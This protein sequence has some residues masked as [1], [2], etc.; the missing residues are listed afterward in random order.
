MK[1]DSS[2]EFDPLIRPWNFP[3]TL[4]GTDA[5]LKMGSSDSFLCVTNLPTN[6]TVKQFQELCEKFGPVVRCFLIYH[7]A[8]DESLGFGLV[9]YCSRAVACQAKNLLHKKQ[10]AQGE[11]H[12]DW[13]EHN[14]VN[15][16]DLYPRC[17]YVGNLPT[18]FC[19]IY[20]FRQLFTTVASPTYCQ[21]SIVNGVP[22]GFGVVEFR[23][24][25]DARKTKELLHGH[26]LNGNR[27]N[28]LFTSPGVSAYKL[29]NRIIEEQAKKLEKN[30][31]IIQ[32]PQL[33]PALLA[34]FSVVQNSKVAKTFQK[35]IN[36]KG[37]GKNASQVS[38]TAASNHAL[39]ALQNFFNQ[40]ICTQQALPHAVLMQGQ[41]ALGLPAPPS[42]AGQ[43]EGQQPGSAASSSS[44]G[45]GE[46][47][48]KQAAED[49]GSP[50]ERHKRKGE[51]V[52]QPQCPLNY[53]TMDN[54]IVLDKWSKWNLF[55]VWGSPKPVLD[56]VQSNCDAVE[57][58]NEA[59]NM[60][61][62]SRDQQS[63]PGASCSWQSAWAAGGQQSQE[64]SGQPIMQQGSSYDK[65][66][67]DMSPSDRKRKVHQLMPSP[68]PSPEH[69]YI[70]QHSQALGGH[71]ADSY[72]RYK[73]MKQ[74]AKARKPQRQFQ[75]W[76]RSSP[77]SSTAWDE[78]LTPSSSSESIRQRK[79]Q[80]APPGHSLG[81]ARA[82]TAKSSKRRPESE[83]VAARRSTETAEVVS[84]DETSLSPFIVTD[85]LLHWAKH[86]VSRKS[87][88]TIHN[89]AA[90][91]AT[92][93]ERRPEGSA[94]VNVAGNAS[95]MTSD[96]GRLV[97]DGG[98]KKA[99]R[100][101]CA[102]PGRHLAARERKT[103]GDSLADR[104]AAAL[105]NFVDLE[106]QRIT[107]TDLAYPKSSL[108]G[109]LSFGIGSIA[110]R[111]FRSGLPRA[112][113]TPVREIQQRAPL[114]SLR[115]RSTPKRTVRSKS[116]GVV[117]GEE[118]GARRR[119]LRNC[120]DTIE[121]S[122]HDLQPLCR[123]ARSSDHHDRG[124]AV[125]RATGMMPRE[126]SVAL[127]RTLIAAPHKPKRMPLELSGGHRPLSPEGQGDTQRQENRGT[128]GAPDPRVGRFDATVMTA[129][130]ESTHRSRKESKTARRKRH[131]SKEDD[132]RDRNKSSSG[133]GHSGSKSRGERRRKKK[134]RSHKRDGDKSSSDQEKTFETQTNVAGS[135]YEL[136]G[137]PSRSFDFVIST[138][139]VT[140]GALPRPELTRSR[141]AQLESGA[142]PIGGDVESPQAM[143]PAVKSSIRKPFAPSRK[144]ENREVNL[145]SASSQ[146]SRKKPKRSSKRSSKKK[147]AFRSRKEAEQD[148]AN[149]LPAGGA[150][151]PSSMPG[152]GE[153]SPQQRSE[154][155]P[156]HRSRSKS[157]R[158]SRENKETGVGS[159]GG[160]SPNDK[161]RRRKSKRKSREAKADKDIGEESPK[162]RKTRKSREEKANKNGE[163]ESPNDMQDRSKRKR[164]ET[165]QTKDQKGAGEQS[166][167]DRDE[168]KSKRKSRHSKGKKSARHSGRSSSQGDGGRRKHRRREKHDR[169]R[170][171]GR[172]R[173]K[174]TP[175]GAPEN[176]P[177]TY[178]FQWDTADIPGLEGVHRDLSFSTRHIEGDSPIASPGSPTGEETHTLPFSTLSTSSLRGKKRAQGS[179]RTS[180]KSDRR[181]PSR[182]SE[183]SSKRDRHRH[184]SRRSHRRRH[185]HR[186][187]DQLEAASP[188]SPASERA[189]P[190]ESRSPSRPTSPAGPRSPS[191]QA[192]PASPSGMISPSGLKSPS[193]VS[194]QESSVSPEPS[195]RKSQHRRHGKKHRHGPGRS[196]RHKRRHRSSRRS[197]S[198]R[199]RPRSR[200]RS[201]QRG[202][203]RH[204]STRKH[205]RH[206]KSA[207]AQSSRSKDGS[208]SPKR[209]PETSGSERTTETSTKSPDASREGKIG[210][211]RSRTISKSRSRRI[212]ESRSRSSRGSRS[213]SRE[214]KS[215]SRSSES[216]VEKRT[217]KRHGRSGGSR[218]SRSKR[219]RESESISRSAQGTSSV[220]RHRGKKRHHRHRKGHGKSRHRKPRSETVS[221]TGRSG[222]MRED[223]VAESYAAQST[224][225]Y[226]CLLMSSLAA[227]L[228]M[229]TCVLM[230]YYIITCKKQLANPG[231][232][233]LSSTAQPK[234]WH[235]P[236]PPEIFPATATPKTLQVYYCTTDHCKREARY[237]SRLLNRQ[238]RPC[239][240][241]YKHVCDIWMSEHPAHA[242]STGSVVSRDTQLQ[243]SIARQLAAVVGRSSQ[244]DIKVAANLFNACTDRGRRATTS[245]DA[246]RALF[247]RWKIGRWPRTTAVENVMAVWTFAGELSRDLNL[248]T[249][250][251]A[252]VG[253]DPENVDITAIELSQPR[254]LYARLGK[255]N[256]EAEQLLRAAVREAV[257]ELGD[258][259][260]AV[261]ALG[262]QL[263][264]ACTVIAAACRIGQGDDR[265]T[266][267]KF[268]QL[269]HLGLQTFLTVLLDGA[270]GG[271]D[272]VVLHSVHNFLREL[273]GTLHTLPPQDTLNYLG[274][275]AIVH[276][277]PFLS[278]NLR[279]L[280]QLFTEAR[281]GRTVG[282][283][284]DT[285]MLCTRLVERA[286]PGCF[287][288][289]AHM[290][291][292]SMGLETETREWL[293]QLE[294]VF[295]RHVAAFPWMSELSSLLIRYRVKRRALTQF[296]Q[297]PGEER[298]SACAP[299]DDQLSAD[300][301]LL[302]F[303]NVSRH[304]QAQKFHE[305]RGDSALLR[306]RA[307]GSEFSTEA[308]FRR[309]LRVVH[310]PAALFNTS[311]PSNSSFFVFHLARVAVRFYQALV[312]LLYQDPYERD[313]PL[314]FT[315][316][317]R[318]KLE[319]LLRCYDSDVQSSVAAS[320]ASPEGASHLRR[321]FLDRTSALLLA[322]RAFEELLP[323]RR[324][325]NL[326]MRLS[327]LEG[328]SA[329]QLFFIYFALDNCESTAP[330][331]HK[332]SMSA[333]DRVNVPL[334]HI[335]QFAEAYNCTAQDPMASAGHGSCSVMRRGYQ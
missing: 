131:R 170:K 306:R 100:S 65:Q 27:L 120:E 4:L 279:G 255:D 87:H 284:M 210:R 291:R 101:V 155:K 241:F 266:V 110:R 271:S 44:S 12:C 7:H 147:K 253:T 55:S 25:E 305:L 137:S 244:R 270:I 288:K 256:K 290:W 228:T 23:L 229:V 91:P 62:E 278:E 119:S 258:S 287:S 13:L 59:I 232:S 213:R 32:T 14:L 301:P 142:S 319:A 206:R 257:A 264:S 2:Y 208:V 33:S 173:K 205:R 1:V 221:G 115:Y 333:E 24:H 330:A 156:K 121:E 227:T 177:N 297:S 96:S 35:A 323:V 20:A 74:K 201:H 200:G 230:V 67:S 302:F 280:R 99:R 202:R 47:K 126:D 114:G 252:G 314:S 197:G 254:C 144:H 185:H 233:V 294:S 263:W 308:S 109:R 8:T 70:G 248:A 133:R 111:L 64:Q 48:A 151:S 106:A 5:K 51:P 34:Q 103:H 320:P 140:R 9:E 172:H 92:H 335:R 193:S 83:D 262:S 191:G 214:S 310:V 46:E 331:F 86:S 283:A 19:D 154:R 112:L 267:V 161:E 16:A 77:R 15:Y 322:M 226:L 190:T 312:Q 80:F 242:L 250:V 41:M 295:L 97:Y 211:T 237:I 196:P 139:P 299:L 268:G 68:E 118:G 11:I 307:A 203:S 182:R 272:D 105:N 148:G 98:H 66:E 315:E 125:R 123:D 49:G 224:P 53:S 285:A 37:K 42:E 235:E 277:A 88:G 104:R 79:P 328:S 29:Y 260:A 6:W 296:G 158:K 130:G 57:A 275:L 56:R 89:R 36:L 159:D 286:L 259:G 76:T 150:A 261:D 22:Q 134:S 276:V 136:S 124:S 75:L 81:I 107:H 164:R 168:R 238:V 102:R 289:A 78:V 10:V 52:Y 215:R 332:S 293:T 58:N 183:R 236:M 249:L 179:G 246:I 188:R 274:F 122:E 187:K 82:T 157:K 152:S 334:K 218:R 176:E 117:F 178:Y 321:A 40:Q 317:S 222:K 245:K 50:E 326:D 71:Y 324:I 329:R 3:R 113:P 327:G 171:H 192:S 163:E 240:N 194:S 198:H 195:K 199:S 149:E 311:V 143:S 85:D 162:E 160:E 72:F 239:D 234:P 93:G 184:R 212:R 243:D 292:L 303:V 135:T 94:T 45:S 90:V 174:Y 186:R 129:A 304:R 108:F 251:R 26:C 220:R 216:M 300:R 54:S 153:G 225:A 146:L 165:K 63:P 316:D 313:V 181:V 116:Q 265:V 167:K 325:W 127:S 189:S 28:I 298:T 180:R 166:P 204:G 175:E 231:T 61:S 21:L 141:E 132:G 30:N 318:A 138:V 17:L 73:K 31:G 69:G 207:S 18:T 43:Y 219:S 273:K 282:D 169:D 209:S 39:I 38:T 217:K 269:K 128:C 281:L 60:S 223:A 309:S 95:T 84:S 145:I 247:F